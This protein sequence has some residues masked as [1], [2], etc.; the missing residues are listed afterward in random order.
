MT[1][2]TSRHPLATERHLH[3]DASRLIPL[4]G[5][6]LFSAIFILSAPHHFS[7]AVVEAA[8]LQGVPLPDLAVPLAGVVAATGGLSILFGYKTKLGAWLIV[9]FLVPVT[10]FMH[11]FWGVADAQT[12]Q[13]QMAHFMKNVALVGGALAF[14]YFGAG[15]LSVDAHEPSRHAA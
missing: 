6:V 9:L 11:R 3:R 13:M 12:A 2:A 1:T 15:P 10:L 7:N 5:R 8:A 4:A 14:A